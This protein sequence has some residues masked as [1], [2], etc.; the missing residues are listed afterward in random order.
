MTP[1]RRQYCEY[2]TL[3]GYSERT[4]ESYIAAVA[5]LAKHYWRPPDRIS[6]PEIRDYLLWLQR[7]GRSFSTINVAVSGLRLFYAAVLRRPIDGLQECLPRMRKARRKPRVYSREELQRLFAACH[8]PRFR[9]F[10]LTV[11][12]AGLRLNEACH[13]KVGDI[14]SSRMM[15]R[16]EAGKGAKDRYTILS[17]WLLAELRRYYACC[18]PGHWLFP[19]RRDPSRPMI[20]GCAQKMFYAALKMAGLPN[21]GGIHCLRHSFATHLLE[22][23]CDLVALKKLLGHSHFVTTANYIAVTRE[24]L[25][26]VPSPLDPP[27]TPDAA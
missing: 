2:L 22:E 10:L 11:Y 23:G 26:G 17:P 5:A 1:L 4:I 21:R 7:Q 9:A 3:R 27:R 12:G 25:R 24:R 6:G 14:E 8:D 19:S 16:I 15:L 18:R 13:L 20:D